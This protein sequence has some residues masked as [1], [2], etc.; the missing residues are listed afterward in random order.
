MCDVMATK[1]HLACGA[2]N[3]RALVN[4]TKAGNV[5]APDTSRLMTLTSL[6]SSDGTEVR[7]TDSAGCNNAIDVVHR[8][9]GD[10]TCTLE[11]AGIS[12]VQ[13]VVGFVGQ[14]RIEIV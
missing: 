12:G 8:P 9:I 2:E 11:T 6:L 10:V 3:V 4:G 14:R 1:S 13:T 5:L 7:N